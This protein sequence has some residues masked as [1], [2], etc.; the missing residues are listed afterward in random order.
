MPSFQYDPCGLGAIR[1]FGVPSEFITGSSGFESA[2]V[3]AL[4]QKICWAI[5]PCPG[6]APA[7]RKSIP[8]ASG[9]AYFLSHSTNLVSAYTAAG[10]LAS[11]PRVI[12]EPRGMPSSAR[13]PH[14]S[15]GLPLGALVAIAGHRQPGVGEAPAER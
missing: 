6:T 7:S 11:P 2:A 14:S 8:A 5:C 10:P 12:E 3:N 9:G 15:T 1:H 13:M 4:Y